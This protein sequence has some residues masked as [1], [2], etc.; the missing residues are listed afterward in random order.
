MVLVGRKD[1]RIERNMGGF[2]LENHK[3]IDIWDL[4][5]SDQARGRAHIRIS[6]LLTHKPVEQHASLCGLGICKYI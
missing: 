2:A 3:R 1:A 4:S 5:R 6:E